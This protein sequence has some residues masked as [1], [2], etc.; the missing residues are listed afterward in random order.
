MEN[1]VNC[2][3]EVEETGL[4][5]LIPEP[6]HLTMTCIASIGNSRK[7]S[8]SDN[9]LVYIFYT[10]IKSRTHRHTNVSSRKEQCPYT[11]YTHTRVCVLRKVRYLMRKLNMVNLED[12]FYSNISHLSFVYALQRFAIKLPPIQHIFTI[13]LSI[14]LHKWPHHQHLFSSDGLRLNLRKIPSE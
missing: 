9:K 1:Y 4:R 3:V 5:T 10:Q 6:K 12:L 8:R 14:S 13:P 2:P 7:R 11:T